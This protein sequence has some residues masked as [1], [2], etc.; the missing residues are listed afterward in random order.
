MKKEKVWRT[1]LPAKR[2]HGELI[3]CNNDKAQEQRIFATPP[4]SRFTFVHPSCSNVP[5]QLAYH[6]D[7]YLKKIFAKQIN[8]LKIPEYF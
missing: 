5:V 7:P 1:P 8:Q 4:P 6:I 3:S 2:G